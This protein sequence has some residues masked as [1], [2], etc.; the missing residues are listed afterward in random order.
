MA[1]INGLSFF[2]KM[3]QA[4]PAGHSS[5]I[6]ERS[7]LE[8]ICKWFDEISETPVVFH[9]RYR[10]EEIGLSEKVKIGLAIWGTIY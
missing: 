6:D 7:H 3:A 4:P 9:W 1:Q 5:E 2:G 10:M 8:R